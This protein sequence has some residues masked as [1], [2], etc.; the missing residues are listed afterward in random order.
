[1]FHDQNVEMVSFF[2]KKKKEKEKDTAVCE[3]NVIL[4]GAEIT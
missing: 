3:S 2:L 4:Y 1:M